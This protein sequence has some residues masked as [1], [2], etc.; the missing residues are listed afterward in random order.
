MAL[1]IHHKALHDKSNMWISEAKLRGRQSVRTTF[2]LPVYLIELL[3]IIAEQFG[4]NQ[5]S[6]IDQ[7]IEDKD[8]LNEVAEYVVDH[9]PENYE[10]RSKTYVLSRQALLALERVAGERRISRDILVEFSIRRLLPV[11]LSEREKHFRRVKILGE[12]EEY[13]HH[14][15]ELLQKAENLL[16]K[17]DPVYEMMSRMIGL[18]NETVVNVTD[19]VARGKTLENVI[20]D[21]Y[22]GGVVNGGGV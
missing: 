3:G 12:I 8:V 7:L 14:G 13:L 5:K 20:V 1:T 21:N 6:L 10:R 19:I 15:N 17:A 11:M 9:L 2:R 18:G 22:S 16:G 4:V